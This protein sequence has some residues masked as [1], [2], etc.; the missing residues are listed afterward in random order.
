[1]ITVDD[2]RLKMLEKQ[3]GEYRRKMP[4]VLYRALNRAASN[5]R[6]NAS[7]EVRQKYIVKAGDVKG[8]ISIKRATSKRIAAAVIS[9]GGAVGLEKFRVSPTQP[10]P[11]K[12]PRALK[13][14]VRKDSSLKKVLGSFVAGVNGNKVF[15]RVPG[16][17]HVKGKSGRW[18]ELPIQRLFGPPVPEMLSNQEVWGRLE[19]Q[20]AETFEKRLEHE[21]NRMFGEGK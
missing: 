15:R 5:L 7:K 11:E 20:A 16:S 2:S 6:T 19:T 10:R 3:L 13:A 8:T 4:I 21:V 14:R 18:T 12:P 1:M 9:K 17:K